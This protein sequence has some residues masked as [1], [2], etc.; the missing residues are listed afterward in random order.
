MR[1]EV[2]RY[3]LFLIMIIALSPV[4]YSL[5][6]A[7]SERI[8]F[9]EDFEGYSDGQDLLE[10]NR[11]SEDTHRPFT[12]SNA[13]FTASAVGR[14]AVIGGIYNPSSGYSYILSPE[15][16][17]S[18][19]VLRCDVATDMM[20]SGSASMS[21]SFSLIRGG[22][23]VP[24]NEDRIVSVQFRNMGIA[25]RIDT[26]DPQ[27]VGAIV[28][29]GIRANTWYGFEVA[30]DCEEGKADI[31]VYDTSGELL[32]SVTDVDLMTSA[33]SVSW[34]EL[35]TTRDHDGAYTTSYWDNITLRNT[36]LEDKDDG[37]RRF[38]LPGFEI[39]L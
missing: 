9:R 8:F 35:I 13:Q 20:Y 11:W 3:P 29:S 17:I 37:C 39:S 24:E 19:G 4:L 21:V 38:F 14:S 30:F 2:I 6:S 28:E 1:V 22:T 15:L 27:S 23:G 18:K 10:T 36:G 12:S 31:S 33:E 25:Y 5:G 16:N 34:I 7:S 32:G 26:V